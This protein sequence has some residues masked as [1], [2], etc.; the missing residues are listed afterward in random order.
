MESSSSTR[1][2]KI[3]VLDCGSQY[4]QLIARRI[5]ELGVYSEI[6]PWD[7]PYEEVMKE[8]PKGVVISGGPASVREEDSP[9]VPEGVLS[10]EV[11]VLGICYGMQLITHLLGGVVKKG[12]F[13]E[14]GRAIVNVTD[15]EAVIFHNVKSPLQV[16]MSHWDYVD[17]PPEGFKVAARSESGMIASIYNESLGIWA[18]QFH[19]EVW[20]TQGGSKILENFLFKVCQCEGLWD[21]QGWIDMMVEQI[22]Q[23][24]GDE[25]VICGLSGGVDSTVA[26]VLTH[27]AIGDNL[28]CIFVDNG[29]LRMNEAQEVLDVYKDLHL[30][31]H[32][33]D[34]SEEFL[35]ALKDVTDP[36]RK[37]KIIGEVF[38]RVFERKAKEIG[39]A[40]WLLQGTVY[41]DV[42]ESG[43]RGKDAAVIKSHHN[44]G[45]LP[46]EMDLKVLEPLRDLFK[47]EVRKIGGMIGVPE[48]ILKR[49]PFPGPGLAVRCLGEITPERLETLRKADKIFLEE[50]KKEGIYDDMWQAF[51]VLLPVKTVGVMGDIRTYAEIV[52]LRAVSSQDGMTA[53]W[54]KLPM[55]LLDRVSRRICN[56][57]PGANRV[58]YDVT[59]KPP[60]TIEWE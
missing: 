18:L 5:R 41:P 31:V 35:S 7:T 37:R 53:D 22:R 45:G 50:I 24:V 48:V 44:V 51:C 3:I 25:K 29:L 9:T 34:A 21:L 20:H 16:W 36:E 6:L 28:E 39:G 30:K 17:A 27:K 38:I 4:T 47:D 19:P 11:P 49:H 43:K 58:V 15:P 14:Y 2:E 57:V 12:S 13:A 42:I 54:V 60:S 10:G 8:E 56:E 26:A 46:E 32:A 33:A 52:G 23:T 1:K 55:G 40:K 59:S